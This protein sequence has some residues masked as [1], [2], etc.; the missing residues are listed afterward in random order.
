MTAMRSTFVT[1]ALLLPVASVALAQPAPTPKPAPDTSQQDQVPDLQLLAPQKEAAPDPHAQAPGQAPGQAQAPAQRQGTGRPTPKAP[2]TDDQLLGRLAKA[3]DRRAARPIERELQARWSHSG[4]PSADLLLK[5]VDDAMEAHD[6]DTAQDIVVKLTT[7]APEFAEAWHRRAS[8]ATQKDDYQDALTSLRHALSLQP[9][10]FIALAELGGI[11]EE[12]EDK[13]HAL[14]A[15]RQAK[16][17]DPYI[18]GLDDRIRALT[19]DV[20]GQGI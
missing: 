5:R 19:K 10:N 9:K 1:L 16:A 7:I 12:F 15:Y 4:S 3:P 14:E 11:L 13:E 17:L 8:L 20:E 18:D 2:E 6:F